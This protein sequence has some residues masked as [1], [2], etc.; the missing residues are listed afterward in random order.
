[1]LIAH[2]SDLHVLVPGDLAYNV[3]NTNPLV[4]SAIAH[5]ANLSPEIVVITGDLVHNAQIAEYQRLKSILSQLTM[6]VY[7]LPGNHDNRDLI[8]QVFTEHTYLPRTGCLQYTVEGHPLR[9]IMLDTNVPGKGHGELDSDRIDWLDQQLSHHPHQPTLLFMHHPPFNT[10]IDLMDSIG[11]ISHQALAAVVKKYDCIERIGCGHTHRPIQTRWAGTLAYTV[12]SP[13]HQVSLDLSTPSQASTFTMEPPAYQIHL[14][15]S[16]RGLV[17]HLQYVNAYEGPYPFSN[18][19][20][21][22]YLQPP[23]FAAAF[24]R[25][26]LFRSRFFPQPLFSQPLLSSHCSLQGFGDRP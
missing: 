9:L 4:E 13:V 18:W 1:M 22:Q 8:R 23:F 14:W 20:A 2:I 7:L 10:G 6:P 26:R 11:L 3:V 21:H 12:P 24:F 16:D 25:S 17:S 19:F 15:N 5:M